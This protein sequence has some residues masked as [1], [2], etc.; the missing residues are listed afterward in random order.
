MTLTSEA[1]VNDNSCTFS[2]SAA[3][4]DEW[5]RFARRQE[6]YQRRCAIASAKSTDAFGRLLA[7]AG[8][9]DCE[10]AERIA[11]FIGSCSIGRR[12]LDLD[13]FLAVDVAVSDD[14]LAVLDYLRLGQGALED[15]VPNGRSQIADALASFETNG[16]DHSQLTFEK[17]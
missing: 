7:L 3:C 5:T 15:L 10:Q 12:H 11:A 8:N 2:A 1:R 14:M 6:K 16:L 17:D 9:S 4:T 13:N